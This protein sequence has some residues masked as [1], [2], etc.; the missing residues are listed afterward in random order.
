MIRC[1]SAMF[2]HPG[3]K[4]PTQRANTSSTAR[5]LQHDIFVELLKIT[6]FKIIVETWSSSTRYIQM[7]IAMPRRVF[8]NFRNENNDSKLLEGNGIVIF[9]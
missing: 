5:R 8:L 2:D 3:H 6:N 9:I 4:G 7:T 1:I